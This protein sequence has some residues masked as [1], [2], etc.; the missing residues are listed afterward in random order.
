M[1]RKSVQVLQSEVGNSRDSRINA[2]IVA[3]FKNE[4]IMAALEASDSSLIPENDARRNDNT[5]PFNKL[6]R[7]RTLEAIRS[8]RHQS[9]NDVSEIDS[10]VSMVGD[11]EVKS[12]TD[13]EYSNI[14]RFSCGIPSMDHIYGST[15]VVELTGQNKGKPTGEVWTGMPSGFI[16]VWGGTPGVG[17]SRLSI[18]VTK[19]LNR[20]GHKVLYFNGEVDESQ[21]RTWC[22]M[23]VNPELFLV[24]STSALHL[25]TV[26]NDIRKYQP[27]VVFIDSLQ[28]IQAAGKLNSIIAS[29]QMLKND[30]SIGMPHIV[31][32]SQLNKKGELKGSRIL[33]HMVDFVASVTKMEGRQGAFCFECPRKNRGGP[34]P[35][36]GVFEHHNGTIRAILDNSD[37]D[38]FE[39]KPYNAVPTVVYNEPIPKVHKF[40][41]Q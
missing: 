8:V 27:K 25:E 20:L 7:Q 11:G 21:F 2:M 19:S 15:F 23:D 36:C 39:L 40:I 38:N 26:S 29:L 32:I 30:A 35:R 13:I 41:P 18:A 28:M 16:S 14:E 5:L 6:H 22:G 34:T 17:K 33:E 9:K 10:L 24:R 37:D 4:E 1:A 31:L 3:G 12:I